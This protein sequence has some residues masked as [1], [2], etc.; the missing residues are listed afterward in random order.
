V[1]VETTS[2]ARLQPGHATHRGDQ[3]QTDRREQRWSNAN[4]KFELVELRIS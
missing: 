1:T 2:P 4:L 3:S